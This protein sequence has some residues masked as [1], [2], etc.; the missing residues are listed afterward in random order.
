MKGG[1]VTL[2]GHVDRYSEKWTAEQA[3]LKVIG[4]KALAIEIEVILPFANNRN[5]SDIA[6]IAETVLMWTT[7]LPNDQVQVIV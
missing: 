2:S 5:D 7:N 3:A 1:M 6:T 4:V